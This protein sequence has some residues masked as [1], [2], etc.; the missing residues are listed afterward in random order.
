MSPSYVQ[1]QIERAMASRRQGLRG[2]VSG[3]SAAK[4]VQL[5]QVSGVAGETF[6][7]MEV[8]QQAGFRSLPLS[9][10]EVIVIPLHGQSAHGV[11]I[12]SANGQLHVANMQAG[13]TAIYNETDGH[14]IHLKNGKVIRMEAQVI[15]LVA[16]QKVVVDSPLLDASGEVKDA[17]GTLSAMRGVFNAH[18]HVPAG[19]AVDHLMA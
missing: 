12:A 1:R 13:E 17:V 5:A 19:G 4:R 15:E 9:G 3:L 10:T 7:G 8:F 6:Q 2:K 18:H 11:V 14:F 16:S